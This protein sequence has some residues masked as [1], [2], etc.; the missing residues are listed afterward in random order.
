MKKDKDTLSQLLQ[1]SCPEPKG[2]IDFEERLLERIEHQKR[3]APQRRKRTFADVLKEL[4]L[5]PLAV[6]LP[7]LAAVLVYKKE[8][9]EFLVS[10]FP[11][12][13]WDAWYVTPACG[14]LLT[15]VLGWFLAELQRD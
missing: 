1:Q 15:L 11:W 14:A 5:S 13:N 12:L 2:E 6:V 9:Q 4:L 7:A 8:L 10:V 3:L